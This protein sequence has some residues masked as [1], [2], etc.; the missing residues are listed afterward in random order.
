MPR[1]NYQKIIK[2]YEYSIG[3]TLFSLAEDK[4]GV[5][6]L[7]MAPTKDKNQMLRLNQGASLSQGAL[8]VW[9]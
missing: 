7:Q 2:K 9:K 1:E 4:Q 8:L 6:A 5:E 3:T